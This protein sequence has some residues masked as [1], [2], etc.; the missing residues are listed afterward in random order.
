MPGAVAMFDRE[1]RYLAVSPRWM[2]DYA[3]HMGGRL[4]GKSHYEVFPEIPERWKEAHRRGLQGQRVHVQED[5]FVRPDGRVQWIRWEL[6]PWLDDAGEV[7][8]IVIMAEDITDRRAAQLALVE[9]D[10]RLLAELAVLQRLRQV[11]IALVR[12]GDS[13]ALMQDIVDAAL[14]FAGADMGNIQILDEAAGGLTIMAHRGFGEDF[15][16]YFSTVVEH[17]AACGVSLARGERVTV[18]D[19]DDCEFLRGTADLRVLRQAGVRAVCSTPLVTRSNVPVGVV[20]VHF[21]SR[22][23]FAE[24]ELRALDLLA[25]QA[26]DLIEQV[27]SDQKIRE[28]RDHLNAILSTALDAIITIDDR[29]VMRSVNAAAERIFGYTAAEM[30]GKNVSMLMP[31]PY[32]GEHDGYIERYLRTGE[33]RVIGTGREVL[34]RRKDGSV[35]PADLAVCREDRRDIFTGFVRD[36]TARKTAENR[37]REAERL[38][39]IGALAAGL[40]HDMNNVLL[41]VRGR[42]NALEAAADSGALSRA[43]RGHVREIR[44]SVA[45]LQ[46][47]ADGLHFLALDP[48][49]H[50]DGQARGSA[51]DLRLWWTQAGPLLSKAVPK[52]VRVSAAIRAG[53]P[54]AAVPAHGLTQAVLNLVVNAGEAIGSLNGERRGTGRVRIWAERGRSADGPCVRVGVTDNGRGMTEE[55]RRRAFDMFF[56][57]KPR[58]LGTGL[59]LAL[60]RKVAEQAGGR[61]EMESEVGKGTT[62]VMSLPA[63]AAGRKARGSG[64][65]AAISVGDGR[66]GALMRQILD[67]LGVRAREGG[68]EGADVWV[69]E[70]G[71][72]ALEAARR[73]KRRKRRGVLVLFGRPDA[74]AAG[75][76]D[77]LEPVRIDLPD[78]LES[79]RSALVRA[80]TAGTRSG[81]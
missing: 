1:M 36:I 20:S 27:R 50:P 5:S 75:E 13:S 40:G 7:G 19:V 44:K 10:R 23:V 80:A 49:V 16:A 29:G 9:N 45:Y 54:R 15:L 58:G 55:V 8:G 48:D 71:S 66:A 69:T 43:V 78:D 34:A 61:V 6:Y 39:S 67:S 42:L 33:A 3:P 47:L 21:R 56:T 62:V 31:P 26:A 53:L 59:G 73:W 52:N 72:G 2:A 37:L 76:W 60:V 70:P 17:Q 79:V 12:G 30:L 51:T 25:R 65:G 18:E 14:E 32:H 38:A 81:R 57:T 63:A 4:I 24:R 64:R 11:S 41:P 46:Q 28:Q 35:F 77:A 22:H 74:A 68:P